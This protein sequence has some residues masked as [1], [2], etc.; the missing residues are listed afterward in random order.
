MM[1]NDSRKSCYGFH[2][3]LPERDNEGNGKVGE[4]RQC[5]YILT[6]DATLSEGVHLC[7][8]LKYMRGCVRETCSVEDDDGLPDLTIP[9][10]RDGTRKPNAARDENIVRKIKYSRRWGDVASSRSTGPDIPR[11]K[12]KIRGHE[13][14]LPLTLAR[15]MFV[16]TSQKAG[17]IK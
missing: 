9:A 13:P 10:Y 17:L 1:Q 14:N 12:K 3:R 7:E 2:H 15:G 6:K 4:N 5:C 8:Q 11:T 16:A